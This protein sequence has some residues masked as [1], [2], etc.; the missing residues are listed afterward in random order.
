MSSLADA[1]IL[2]V[3]NH[4]DQIQR[5][6][7]ILRDAACRISVGADGLQ[8]YARALAVSPDLILMDVRMPQSDGFAACRLLA[9]DPRTRAI[10]VIFLTA[11]D[12]LA[13]SLEGLEIGGVDYVLT[14]FEPAEVLARIRIHLRRVKRAA[15]IEEAL[16]PVQDS[17]GDEILVRAA[18]RYL[19][20]RLDRPPTSDQLAHM[21]GTNEK[22]LAR[23][24]R[25]YR[26]QTV[27]EYIQEERFRRA[28]DLLSGTGLSTASIAEEI[29]F[30]SSANFATAF[31]ARFGMT[32]S[33]YRN[34]HRVRRA[35]GTRDMR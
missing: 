33:A 20:R 12:D 14:P 13:T 5:L 26:N 23:A 24:F 17:V 10:P 28:T 35:S 27:F 16:A 29:G 7:A 30:S 1:H 2:V 31:R 19:S 32:P 21:V 18:I 6:V 25:A 4:A 15:R 11:R 8:A 22:R 34:T 3:D 9:A